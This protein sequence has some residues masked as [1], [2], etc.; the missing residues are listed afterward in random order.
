MG[1]LGSHLTHWK[2]N[3]TAKDFRVVGLDLIFLQEWP[4]QERKK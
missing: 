4:V 3:F 2:N 1:I